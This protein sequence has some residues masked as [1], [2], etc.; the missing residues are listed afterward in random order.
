[1]IQ[2]PKTKFLNKLL[3]NKHL[4]SGYKAITHCADKK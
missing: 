1:M 2:F 4:P 3:C